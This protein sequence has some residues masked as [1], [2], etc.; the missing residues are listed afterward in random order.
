MGVST[1]FQLNKVRR[2][3]QS[4]GTTFTVKRFGLNEFGETNQ[5]NVTY[6]DLVGLYHEV[7]SQVQLITTE[8]TITKTEPQPR[9][10]CMPD[11]GIKAKMGDE[12]IYKGTKYKVVEASNPLKYDVCADVS[13][14]V[15]TDG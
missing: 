11:E 13:L 5:E 1:S 8:G 12:I 6:Y 3:I 2:L 10:L 9:I 7:N 4:Q 15:I 14:E